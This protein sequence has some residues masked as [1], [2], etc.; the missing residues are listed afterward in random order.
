MPTLRVG[1]EVGGFLETVGVSTEKP[2]RVYQSFRC[3][4]GS[5][6]SPARQVPDRLQS[7]QMRWPAHALMKSL[8][9]M[10]QRRRFRVCSR[11]DLGLLRSHQWVITNPTCRASILVTRYSWVNGLTDPEKAERSGRWVTDIGRLSH[12]YVGV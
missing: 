2:A 6:L 4:P 11:S 5:Q 10:R 12:G 3:S 9:H 7:G 1:A 8:E